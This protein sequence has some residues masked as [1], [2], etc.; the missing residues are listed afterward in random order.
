MGRLRPRLHHSILIDVGIAAALH[1]RSPGAGRR[2][3]VRHCNNSSHPKFTRIYIFFFNH[4][5]IDVFYPL[6]RLELP[7]S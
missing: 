5:H 6:N 3:T 7:L 4:K 2:V 1:R